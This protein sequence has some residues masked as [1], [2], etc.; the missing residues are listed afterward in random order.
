MDGQRA[1][2][3]A[4]RGLVLVPTRELARQ[5]ADVIEPLASAV[6]MSVATV[7]GGVGQNPQVAALRNG[8]DIVVACPGRLEDLVAQGHCR[9]DDV[10]VTV[11]DEA[12]M[13]ADFG[14]LPAVRRLLDATPPAGQRLL[15]SATLDNA[16]KAVVDRYL[17]D[18]VVHSVDPAVAPVPTMV[19]H[20]FEIAAA[21]KPH[22]VY[23]LA[24]GAE[25]VLLF[26]RTK[27]IA[28]K[29]TKALV[30]NG[31]PAVELHG[32]LSQNARVANLAQ[33]ASGETRVLVATDIAARGIHVDDVALVVHVDPPAEHKAF[34][35]GLRDKYHVPKVIARVNDPRN[36][37]HL[38]RGPVADD[39]PHFSSAFTGVVRRPWEYPAW[40]LSWIT[41]AETMFDAPLEMR[42]SGLSPTARYRLR[43][44]YGGE[45][46]ATR[47]QRLVA[48][49]NVELHPFQ[50]I[51]RRTDPVEFDIPAT[52]TAG[53]A[54]ELVWARQPG[55][56][57]AG[58][59]NQ[60]AEVWL[61]RVTQ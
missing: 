39:P 23:A 46:G 33:F 37:P 60:V 14:F 2:R 22:L 36:Q 58:R 42:Y 6:R 31:I 13:M 47:I 21:D 10:E 17:T 53:S 40:R 61:I 52:A 35:A 45:S 34:I 55:L 59:C 27:Y 9:L 5:V 20:V 29:W 7:F 11:L 19:H 38:V 49:G 1:R 50:R 28:K 12:D 56:P 32:N 44:I 15:F 8:A 25:R 4:P 3:G 54:L 43:I 48:N 24:G 26:T 18:P 51:E 30:A 57:G 41:E 16:V